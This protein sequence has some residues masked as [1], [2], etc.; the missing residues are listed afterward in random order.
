MTQPEK[1]P[2]ILVVDD[3]ELILST[4]A[5]MVEE[6]GYVSISK[7]SSID[8]LTL[9]ET[10]QVVDLLISDLVMPDMPGLDLVASARAV[11]PD[12]PAVIV[13]GY[14][15]LPPGTDDTIYSLQKPFDVDQLGTAI[16]STLK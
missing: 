5:E 6:L 1:K 4:L 12:L 2:V 10:D 9:L 3:D 15:Q 7:I 8:A 11:R 13:T 14:D 16:S